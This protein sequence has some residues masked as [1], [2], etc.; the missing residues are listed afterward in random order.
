[1]N[2][3]SKSR[4]IWNA[5]AWQLARERATSEFAL[6]V[7]P[8]AVDGFQI[9]FPRTEVSL[10]PEI[11]TRSDAIEGQTLFDVLHSHKTCALDVALAALKALYQ[12]DI[13]YDPFALFGMAYGLVRKAKVSLGEAAGPALLSRGQRQ[14]LARLAAGYTRWH[15]E[16]RRVLVHGDLHTSNLIADLSAPS[17]AFVDLEMMH[18]GKHATNFAQLWIG[19]H[20]ADPLLGQSLYRRHARELPEACSLQFENDVRAEVALKSYLLVKGAQRTGRAAMVDKARD[21]LV[22]TLDH[23]T[24][25]AVCFAGDSC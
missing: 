20:M 22:S 15:G 6:R 7:V 4:P 13:T 18:I 10:G 19:F 11:R 24:F 1:M 12:V 5:R 23:A 8:A 21:L 17:L 9:Q 3:F 25:E 2:G 16:G 14:S